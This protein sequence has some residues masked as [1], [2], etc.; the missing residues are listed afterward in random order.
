MSPPSLN[1]KGKR[2]FLD[3]SAKD[4]NRMLIHLDKVCPHGHECIQYS[5]SSKNVNFNYMETL[6]I[7]NI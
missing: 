7:R 2:C 3:S 6:I 4:Q 5:K 1:L